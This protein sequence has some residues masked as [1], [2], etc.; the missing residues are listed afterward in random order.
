M[1]LIFIHGPVGAGK[2]TV[3]QALSEQTGL[4]LFHNHMT[5]DA[6]SAVFDFGTAPFVRLRE[7]I[8]LSFFGEA[9][10]HGTSLIFTF[11][12]ERTVRPEFVSDAV[13][14]VENRGGRI[15]FVRLTCPDR[16]IERRVDQPSRAAHGKITS[17]D[18]LRQLRNEGAFDY[19][20]L[21]D[22]GLTL[23]T[24]RISPAEAAERI[25]AFFS[26]PVLTPPRQ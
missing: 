8:W 12:P 19:P 2:L 9:A 17:L 22:S 10:Q 14:V 15:C 1:D 24:S 23:D 13:A 6:V 25:Q 18:F 5:V 20:E 16:E 4:R 11:A 21:P 26:L 3:A 7:Q